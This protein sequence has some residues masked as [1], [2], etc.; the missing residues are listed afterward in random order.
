MFVVNIQL[1][2]VLILRIATVREKSG[3]CASSQETSM[4]YLN[5]FLSKSAIWHKMQL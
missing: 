3:N 1:T 4:F 5:P 2:R